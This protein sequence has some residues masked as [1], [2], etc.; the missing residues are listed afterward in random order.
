MLMSR[1]LRPIPKFHTL[2]FSHGRQRC[3]C[4]LKRHNYKHWRGKLGSS[5][6]IW[7]NPKRM[8]VAGALGTEVEHQ[9]RGSDV[10]MALTGVIS[11][12]WSDFTLYP[13]HRTHRPWGAHTKCFAQSMCREH[14]CVCQ[15][16]LELSF[17]PR[18]MP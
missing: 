10:V 5:N 15:S 6:N 4:K 9:C 3:L 13:S 1:L 16:H 18:Q 8:A 2:L 17:S 12:S 11:F 14:C 7:S